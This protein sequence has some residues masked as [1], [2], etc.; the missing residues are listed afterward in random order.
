[1]N[2]PSSTPTKVEYSTNGFPKYTL[3]NWICLTFQESEYK[4]SNGRY[5]ADTTRKD[6]ATI[7]PYLNPNRWNWKEY[8][9]EDWFSIKYNIKRWDP[10]A[11]KLFFASKS[12]NELVQIKKD[13]EVLYDWVND[14]QTTIAYKNYMETH[15]CSS[16][17]P[18]W[19]WYVREYQSFGSKIS[20]FLWVIDFYIAEYETTMKKVVVLQQ[21]WHDILQ[22]LLDNNNNKDARD[23]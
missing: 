9:W 22:L 23:I 4:E 12:K 6:I 15:S 18:W 21:A 5:E 1:M 16:W 20:S 7:Y 17:W 3:S 10:N 8:V 13:M 14:F 2:I 11:Y 19:S